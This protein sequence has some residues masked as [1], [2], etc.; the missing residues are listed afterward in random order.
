MDFDLTDEQG[1]LKQ[2]VANVVHHA[3]TQGLVRSAESTSDGYS[4]ALTRQLTEIGLPGLLAPENCGG[5]GQSLFEFALAAEQLGRGPVSTPLIAQ[6]W[7]A[8]VPLSHAEASSMILE[9]AT[10][11]ASGAAIVTM[12]HLEP[13]MHDEWSP[14]TTEVR[15]AAGGLTLTGS[16][17]LVPYGGS[18]SAVF[19]SAV[20]PKGH[21][22]ICLVPLPRDGARL[23]AQLATGGDPMYRL[24]LDAVPIPEENMVLR[25]PAAE[26][27]I[28][29]SLA[30]GTVL[31]LAYGV[32][33][34]GEATAMSARYASERTQFGRPIG[35]FQ[36][37]AHRC[38][39]MLIDLNA[40]RVLVYRAVWELANGSESEAAEAVAIAKVFSD[41]ALSRIFVNAHQIHGAIGFSMEYDLQLFTRR[42]KAVELGFG[43]KQRHLK[44]VAACVGI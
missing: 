16:K 22:C 9:L 11:L 37:V 35:S 36:A 25:G 30:A 24:D 8:Q 41:D 7:G 19:V 1:L 32:G 20:M 12:A 23:T 27:A 33:L 6:A 31:E 38:A 10:R 42:A 21:D 40:A 29:A 15:E 28:A 18:A 4:A 26:S 13:G 17:I 34:A 44:R 3:R 43:I 5:T 14:L 2:T 39:D